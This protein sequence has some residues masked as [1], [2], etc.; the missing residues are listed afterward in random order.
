LL[1]KDEIIVIQLQ[2]PKVQARPADGNL[3]KKKNCRKEKAQFDMGFNFQDLLDIADCA[4]SLS[5]D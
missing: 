2:K 4:A 1:L 5:A 3:M